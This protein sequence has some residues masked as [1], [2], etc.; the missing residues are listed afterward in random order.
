MRDRTLPR[1]LC[2]ID[3]VPGR[4]ELPDLQR[5]LMDP[6]TQARA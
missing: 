6:K 4:S 2:I 3:A 1:V 5:Q